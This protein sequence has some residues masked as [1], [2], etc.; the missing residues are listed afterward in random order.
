MQRKTE[1][2][3]VWE[4]RTK[5]TGWGFEYL[6]VH[7]L[8]EAASEIRLESWLKDRL[9]P[10]GHRANWHVVDAKQHAIYGISEPDAA[11]EFETLHNTVSKIPAVR[12]HWC[13]HST[14]PGVI[15]PDRLPLRSEPLYEFE[16][17]CNERGLMRGY[18]RCD[19]GERVL[20]ATDDERFDFK[21][22]WNV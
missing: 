12:Y 15:F 9:G 5:L 4:A 21:M 20:F 8:D 17:W 22:R 2:Q 10:R 7:P 6:I 14:G 11:A 3:R 1:E 16:A 13:Q 18:R 19:P